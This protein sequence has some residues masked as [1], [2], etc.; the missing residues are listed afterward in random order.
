[1]AVDNYKLHIKNLLIRKGKLDI[2]TQI[3]QKTLHKAGFFVY[4]FFTHVIIFTYLYYF[5]YTSNAVVNSSAPGGIVAVVKT[6]G[7]YS[8]RTAAPFII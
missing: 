3:K 6:D 5:L 1:M 7:E 2:S 8:I 4:F